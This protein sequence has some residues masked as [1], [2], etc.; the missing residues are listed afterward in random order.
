MKKPD[1]STMASDPTPIRPSGQHVLEITRPV[2]KLANEPAA[3]SSTP[4]YCEKLLE[5]VGEY[6]PM[7]MRSTGLASRPA[8]WKECLPQFP[9]DYR[10]STPT[11]LQDK[12]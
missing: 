11:Y 6:A 12:H 1:I 9:I 5:S 10:K 7:E 4:E 8:T 3:I 2:A